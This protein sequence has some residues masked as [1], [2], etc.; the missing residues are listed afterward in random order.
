MSFLSGKIGE[1]KELSF[2]GRNTFV[3]MEVHLLFVNIPNFYV[4]HAIVHGSSRYND[5][6]IDQFVNNTW[7]RYSPNTRLAGFFC[8]VI[9]SLMIAYLLERA[10]RLYQKSLPSGHSM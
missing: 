1:R 8:G 3:I 10:K 5:F 7:V 9:G 6:P 4:Y 2:I